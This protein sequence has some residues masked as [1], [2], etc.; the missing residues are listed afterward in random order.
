M[1]LGDTMSDGVPVHN[2]DP[3]PLL[4]VTTVYTT[5]VSVARKYVEITKFCKSM[6]P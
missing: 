2:V 1:L 5:T 6:P 3:K 4:S